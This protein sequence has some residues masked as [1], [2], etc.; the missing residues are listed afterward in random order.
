MR[1]SQFLLL[2]HAPVTGRIQHGD[3][4]PFFLL[5]TSILADMLLTNVR[6]VLIFGKL[7]CPPSASLSRQK[8]YV[9]VRTPFSRPFAQALGTYA[10]RRA[11]G[12]SATSEQSGER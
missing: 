3:V 10:W 11:F 9:G 2:F 12:A 8:S 6:A 1:V 5:C 7:D 4:F